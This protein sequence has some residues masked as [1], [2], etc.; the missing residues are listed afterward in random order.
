MM[1]KRACLAVLL[2]IVGCGDNH[3]IDF[4]PELVSHESRIT[5]SMAE[6]GTTTIDATATDAERET[7]TYSVSTPL[8]GTVTGAGHVYLY[9]PLANY[10]GL[11]SFTISISDGVN[12]T[13]VSVDITIVGANDAPVADD[14]QAVTNEDQGVVVT[15]VASDVDTTELSYVLVALP[16]HGT[17]TGQ[18]PTLTFTPDRHYFGDD[19]FT[20]Q[21]SDGSLVSSPATV[22]ISVANVITCGDGVVEGAEQCDD[23]NGV[24]TD[25]CLNSCVVAR[26]GDG[27]VQAVVEACDDGNQDDTDGCHNDCTLPCAGLCGDGVR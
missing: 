26:C 13:D 3:N 27:V 5:V 1:P 24:N 15:M 17:L 22:S 16:A 12:T 4:P 23:G 19:S 20:F 8:R 6:D 18:P 7:L 9:T 21:V 10:A 11:D 14:S 2:G 25:G